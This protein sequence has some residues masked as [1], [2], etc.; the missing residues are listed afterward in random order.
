MEEQMEQSLLRFGV[1]RRL[2][3]YGYLVTA[4]RLVGEGTEIGPDLL[5]QVGQLHGR[6][7]Y[8]VRAGV[9]RVLCCLPAE[10]GRGGVW[11]G[12][13]NL[14]RWV[15]NTLPPPTGKHMQG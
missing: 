13:Q 8:Q 12:L 2:V 11:N 7:Y 9:R 4:A 3:G 10:V 14:F 5:A 15:Q 1:S 6:N